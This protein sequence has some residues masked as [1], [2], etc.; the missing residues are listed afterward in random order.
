MCALI[1][2]AMTGQRQAPHPDFIFF[3]IKG[4]TGRTGP[5]C[6]GVSF[7]RGLGK[8]REISRLRPQN[9]LN[10]SNGLKCEVY[11]CARE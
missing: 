1:A 2:R 4:R 5:H 3:E 11:A 8:L 7:T 10:G 9:G 6:A